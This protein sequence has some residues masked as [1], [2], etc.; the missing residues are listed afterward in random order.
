MKKY[1]LLFV[2]YSC[3]LLQSAVAATNLLS[4]HLVAKEETEP[5]HTEPASLRLI[6]P[7]VLAD[8]DFVSFDWTN[9]TFVITP[10]AA[11]RLAAGIW[12]RAGRAPT[13]LRD[14]RYLLIPFP[15]PFV[16]K[17][18]GESV[19]V[20]AFYSSVFSSSFRG[21]VVLSHTFVLSSSLTSNV[22]FDIELGYPAAWP[23]MADPR[24]ERRIVGAV[25][26]LFS[27]EKR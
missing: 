15:T 6:S 9:Q 13:L 26:N 27:H 1:V 4:I 5:W 7:P 10:Q 17:A 18:S 20:G 14:G 16:M 19:Y 11:Q 24:R 12:S 23:G 22:T 3:H 8:A 25:Q 21:P 2:V